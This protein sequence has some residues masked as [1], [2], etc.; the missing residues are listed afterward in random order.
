MRSLSC[1][2]R[3]I[4]HFSKAKVPSN[5][6]YLRRPDAPNI[7]PDILMSSPLF[8]DLLVDSLFKPG[9]H[10]NPE[11]KSKYTYILGY[12]TSVYETWKGDSRLAVCKDELK[13]TVQAIDRVHSV[14][15][16]EIGGTLQLSSEVGMLYQCIR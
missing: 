14:C 6:Q 15:S 7:L 8:S 3:S 10:I 5:S 4:H 9:S 13:G 2:G 11:H 12:S 16:R 1:S